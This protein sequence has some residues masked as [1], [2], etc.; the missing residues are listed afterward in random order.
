MVVLIYCGLNIMVVLIYDGLFSIPLLILF[1][2]YCQILNHCSVKLTRY[3]LKWV[4]LVAASL[5][6]WIVYWL[7]L[8][9]KV[10][11]C[12]YHM[13]IFAGTM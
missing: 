5:S 8:L 2:F 13:L 10:I 12:C 3:C 1:L 11:G 7:M 4:W 9:Q 6:G